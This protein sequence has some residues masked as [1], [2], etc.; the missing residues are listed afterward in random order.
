MGN[1][2]FENFNGGFIE[3]HSIDEFIKSNFVA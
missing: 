1:Y 2:F 3:I